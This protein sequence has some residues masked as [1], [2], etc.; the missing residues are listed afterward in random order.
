MLHSLVPPAAA[1]GFGQL[2]QAVR[3]WFPKTTLQLFVVGC[4]HLR[5]R[6]EGVAVHFQRSHRLEQGLLERTTH[7]RHLAH[8]LHGGAQPRV[9]AGKLLEREA[10]NL[11]H[12]VVE[13]GFERGR[14]GAGDVVDDLVQPPPEGDLGGDAGDREAGR[15]GG[16]RRR[17]RDPRVHLDDHVAAVGRVD[18]ELDVGPAGGHTHRVEHRACGVAQD[19]ELSV[20]EGLGGSDGDRITGVDSHRVEIFDRADDHEGARRVAHHLE[21]E[22]LPTEHGGLHQDLVGGGGLEPLGQK[23]LKGLAIMG[24]AATPT[25]ER[26]GGAE[27]R[28]QADAVEGLQALLDRAYGGR[29]QHG[30]PHLLHRGSE[31]LTVF[32]K[33]DR[34]NLRAEQANPESLE[35]PRLLQ[36]HRQVEGGLAPQRW[37][38]RIGAFLFEDRGHRRQ[39]Q[40]FDEGAVG[41]TGVGHHGRRVGVDEHHPAAFLDQRA[42]PLDPRVVELAGLADADRPRTKNAH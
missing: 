6:L 31:G 36:L 33:A 15:L 20:G 42:H 14:G 25:S 12:H 19:L 28:G 38:Q 2:P 35:N 26:E 9:G 27:N 8:R 5:R 37:D 3:R 29:G 34:A 4:R 41:E 11:H 21:L 17:T 30:E 10:G 7:R 40:R 16:Q 13:R 32:G 18:R 1:H 22:L 39:G 24:D 23:R